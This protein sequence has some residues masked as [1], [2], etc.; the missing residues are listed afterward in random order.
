[1]DLS[2]PL[3][4]DGGTGTQLQAAGM[5]AGVCTELWA[6]EHPDVIQ[7]VHTSY[8][9]AGSQIIASAT[10]GANAA[11]LAAHNAA[12]RVTELNQTLAALALETAGDH[13]IVAGDLSPTGWLCQ[14]LGDRS[15]SVIYE[16]YREQALALESAGVGCF[17]LETNLTLSD[18]RAGILAIRSVS[19]KPLFVSLTAGENGKTPF[20]CDMTAAMV[21]AQAMGATAFGLN[22][23]SGPAEMAQKLLQLAPYARIP[24]LYKP[25]AGLPQMVNGRSVYDCP[26]E[27]FTAPVPTL[28]QAGVRLFGGCCGSTPTHIAAL[29]KALD[30]L[31]PLPFTPSTQEYLASERE[32]YPIP[33]APLSV[34]GFE[35]EPDLQEAPFALRLGLQDFDDYL[36]LLPLL[37]TPLCLYC[38]DTA[39]LERALQYYQGRAAYA[40]GGLSAEALAPLVTK[41]GLYL[42]PGCN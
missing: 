4:L 24:M 33:A 13:T 10:F 23:S 21:T 15:F 20:G 35:D 36:E 5:P 42:L 9:N 14:P 16:C 31:E 26:S 17:L 32:V 7:A 11:A 22:C 3:L 40:G 30:A 29:R 12:D 2:T 6:I 34:L 18:I 41:Y 1:M 25:N 28:Y 27:E 8:I 19:D 39:V 38:G 37:E